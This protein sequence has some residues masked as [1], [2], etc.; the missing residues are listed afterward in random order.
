[1]PEAFRVLATPQ[2]G[3]RRPEGAVG[4]FEM[5]SKRPPRSCCHFFRGAAPP[6]AGRVHAST[7]VR[8]VSGVSRNPHVH[9]VGD[10]AVGKVTGA[11]YRSD[12]S[13]RNR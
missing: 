3:L 9:R 12:K 6:P 13:Q 11:L 4:V 10:V 2:M 8:V 7:Y 1:M 5:R